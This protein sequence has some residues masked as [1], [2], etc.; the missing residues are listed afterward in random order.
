MSAAKKRKTDGKVMPHLSD[1]Q[2]WVMCWDRK[3]RHRWTDHQ[4]GPHR[5]RETDVVVGSLE[6]GCRCSSHDAPRNCGWVGGW[7]GGAKVQAMEKAATAV[8]TD[9]RVFRISGTVS[10]I[11]PPP[12]R[13]PPEAHHTTRFSLQTG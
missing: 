13:P 12:A 2:L 7:V 4:L 6:G 9:S 1:I 10:W 8:E 3:D 5:P 11:T